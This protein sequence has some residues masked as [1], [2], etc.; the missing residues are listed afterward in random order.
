[1]VEVFTDPDIGIAGS[2]IYF[3]KGHEY[4]RDRYKKDERGKVIWYAGGV[5]DWDNMYASHR[6][7]DEVDQGQ[8]NRIQETP[9]VTGCSMM[10]KKEVFD[11]IGLLDQRL[12]AYLEDVDFC[13]RA[14]Q[15]GYKLL[16]VPQSVIWHT[17]AGSSG[18]G[19]D[20]HQYY[21]TRNR[22]LVGFRYAPLRTKF[23]LLREATRTIIGGSSIRR[24]A[25]LDALIGRLGKQ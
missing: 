17:N 6:G 14:K 15:A 21:M 4:H 1:M 13:V 11:K 12:F 18:V 3:A 19:S 10:I 9:F 25:V 8:F 23:A 16:Y 7:V 5:I 22:L 20:T 24:K 2:K